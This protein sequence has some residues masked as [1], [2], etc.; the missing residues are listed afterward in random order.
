FAG[1]SKDIALVMIQDIEDALERNLPKLEW[2][3]DPTREAAVG[4]I[5]KVK[6]KVGYPNKWKD[7]S[8]MKVGDKYFENEV[9]AGKWSFKRIMDK[10][11]KKVDPDEWFA[12]A[13]IVN[14]FY[15]PLQNDMNFPAGIMQPPFFSA[16]FPKAMNYG[17]IGMVMGHELT[18][19]FDDQ[20]RQ[21]DGDGVMKEW[22]PAEVAARFD[23]RASCIGDTYSAI[24]VQPGVKLNG[25]LTMGE[26]IAD[27]GGIREAFSAYNAHVV[28]N[29]AEA[30]AVEG[31]TNEQLF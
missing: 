29:G 4:K 6:N 31:L 14:A 27:H 16:D 19:G 8:A 25:D 26:N 7:Y 2:M 17:A 9:A 22:W 10:I 21:F 3:D 20:G 18:H 24:E 5:K 13:S 28:K 15:N 12:P 30:Q 11:G 23:E 1:D